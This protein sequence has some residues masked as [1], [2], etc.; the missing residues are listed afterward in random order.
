MKLLVNYRVNRLALVLMIL[1]LCLY[2]TSVFGRVLLCD[3]F[4]EGLNPTWTRVNW[5]S[6]EFIGDDG[7]GNNVIKRGSFDM[8]GGDLNWTDYTV[9]VQFRFLPES[10]GGAPEALK[11][12][13]IVPHYHHGDISY[14]SMNR[15]GILKSGNNAYFSI[16]DKSGKVLTSKYFD[17][18]LVSTF[19]YD[20]HTLAV[21][22]VGNQLSFIIGEEI[23][24]AIVDI[25]DKPSGQVYIIK[26]NDGTVH[27]STP[28][29]L[30]NYIKVIDERPEVVDAPNIPADGTTASLIT[31][32]WD[33]PGAKVRVND[34]ALT[35]LALDGETVINEAIINAS[36]E[37]TF[38][39]KGSVAGS[40]PIEVS[41]DGEPWEERNPDSR[42]Q[43]VS[44]ADPTNSFISIPG[45]EKEKKYPA[46]AEDASVKIKVNVATY[47]ENSGNQGKYKVVLS[48]VEGDAPEIYISEPVF[49][50]GEGEAKFTI[51]SFEAGT[52][53]LQ[54]QIISVDAD[55]NLIAGI[56]P[57]MIESDEPI[58][59]VRAAS[60][61]ETEIMVVDETKSVSAD[62]E[63]T[64]QVKI[65]LED[66][67]G[68]VMAGTTVNLKYDNDQVDI[69]S[70]SSGVTD[71]EGNVIFEVAA[72]SSSKVTI[73]F[74]LESKIDEDSVE[75]RDVKDFDLVFES[76]VKVGD[77]DM[78]SKITSQRILVTQSEKYVG[79]PNDAVPAD[80]ESMWKVIFQLYGE[81]GE[82]VANRKVTLSPG[83]NELEDEDITLTKGDEECTNA[84][85]IIEYNI[86]TMQA[87]TDPLTV[88][89]KFSIEKDKSVIE[90]TILFVKDIFEPV[91]INTIPE[92]DSSDAE[93]GADIII[94]FNEK[95]QLT[96]DTKVVLTSDKDDRIEESY[97]ENLENWQLDDDGRT[98]IWQHRRLHANTN[99]TATITGIADLQDNILKSYSWTFY[100]RDLDPPYV[101]EDENGVLLAR[102]RPNAIE[103]MD[104]VV[105]IPFNEPLKL[106][107]ENKPSNLSIK[108]YKEE[109]LL[110]EIAR[111]SIDYNDYV[112]KSE[113][114]FQLVDLETDSRYTIVVKGAI[115]WADWQM[116]EISWSF[117]TKDT[118]P[119]IVTFRSPIGEI[120]EEDFERRIKVQFA[121]DVDITSGEASLWQAGEKLNLKT[122]SYNE[123]SHVWTLMSEGD[124]WSFNEPY[125]VIIK[126]I[127]KRI[128]NPYG[129]P[130]IKNPLAETV[131]WTFSIIGG[132]P[133]V[134]GL[135]ATNG[136][137]EAELDDEIQ[138][139]FDRII[140]T[141]K[142]PTILMVNIDTG[143]EIVSINDNWE[144]EDGLCKK[145]IINSAREKLFT[146]DTNYRILVENIFSES[147]NQTTSQFA[148]FSTKAETPGSVPVKADDK[149][150]TVP[151]EFSDG[152]LNVHIPGNAFAND[153]QLS[154]SAL[155]QAEIRSMAGQLPQ[156]QAL[157]TG[158]SITPAAASSE[159]IGIEIPFISNEE[160]LVKAIDS[161]G[162]EILVP[163][164]QL[165]VAR[166]R[167]WGGESGEWIPIESSIDNQNK[168]VVFQTDQ[169]GVF[170][171][172][173]YKVSQ[174]KG[175]L[176]EVIFTQNPLIPNEP[177]QRSE[178]TLKFHLGEDSFVTLNVF[179]QNG[180]YLGS[181]TDKQLFGRGY[182]G[183]SWNG[184]VNGKKLSK[185]IYVIQLRVETAERYENNHQVLAVW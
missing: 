166:W 183:I 101:M 11:S 13:V 129:E 161:N 26:Q 171:I 39:V 114:T 61:T 156:Q 103:V 118:E 111:G 72:R 82:P 75:F 163:V 40:Y 15:V 134:I 20:W 51:S 147:G 125:E 69:S 86:K 120:N 180:R 165:F 12:F 110:R 65:I 1:I 145:I 24:S 32:K 154:A 35:M 100:S 155:R 4:S 66:Y 9:E 58:T 2:N 133:Q 172:L 80:G 91:V 68:F 62:G 57:V 132:A 59:F 63:S 152:R 31:V 70:P 90:G 168:K 169:L 140:D 77:G 158:Y 175:L 55:D 119:T 113:I 56:E 81:D 173:G 148:F 46:A 92:N 36:G 130:V 71:A 123:D 44:V 174:K 52:I 116:E 112:D 6:G 17:D 138:I 47:E 85:G 8:Y 21:K 60:P 159:S 14:G 23:I 38:K 79:L 185:G 160:G 150:K 48:P 143:E 137:S 178:T 179:D 122:I 54:A 29:A 127:E 153:I 121:D 95:I 16:T 37:A 89:L 28:N 97:S 128:A 96:A 76:P 74:V 105:V 144:F 83:L 139:L 64:R 124:N 177:G 135:S 10:E 151:F 33:Y 146:A 5:L 30:I 67:Q 7:T 19:G 109:V 3:D 104:P 102:P 27:N 170:A 41:Y 108:L 45:W 181:I 53:T 115:D 107:D 142:V 106:D 99:Y 50:E 34:L 22:I 184:Q 162:N 141:S 176:S 94:V 136:S 126:D 117:K 157:V 98:V 84:Q 88:N 25:S 49:I 43:L 87:L 167:S 78:E 73:P 182:H 164:E 131:S 18:T 42:L 149:S 93:V